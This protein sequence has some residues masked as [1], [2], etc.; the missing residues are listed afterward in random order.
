MVTTEHKES[1]DITVV[2]GGMVGL[3]Q[4]L[5]LAHQLPNTRIAVIENFALN[6]D[7][8]LQPSFDGR[9]TALSASSV[10]LLE[11]LAVWPSL[12]HYAQAIRHVHV[13]DRGHVGKAE[14]SD[15]EN[16]DMPL[17]Y[18]VDNTAFGQQLLN[19]CAKNV[20]I[21]TFAPA[22][23]TSVVPVATGMRV[24]VVTADTQCVISSSLVVIAD[25]VDSALRHK[26]GVG[27]RVHDYQQVAVIA[28]V[29]FSE[30]HCGSAFER[31]T[32]EGPLAVLP[33]L[34]AENK[35]Q[36][37]NRTAVV[38]TR[39]KA[40]LD[41]TLAWSDGEF[42]AQLQRRFGYR[43]GACLR[44]GER[45]FYELKMVFAC[46][47]VRRG[48]VFMG[49]AA[50]FLHPV[51]GQGFNLAVRDCAQLSA[52][53]AEA[54]ERGEALGSLPVLQR[55]LEAQQTDQAITSQLS[56]NFI[57]VFA[58]SHPA[59]QLGRNMGL[60][61]MAL[62]GGLKQQLFGQMMGKALPRAALKRP[63]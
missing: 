18:V 47:Q 44:V 52:V 42:L 45:N 30:P 5:L 39:P 55:Y 51:A 35:R 54:N 23:V 28:N 26:L 62:F 25:G 15:A 34:N 40:A 43:L 63:Q 12:Q 37:S 13:S 46:E 33:M 14:Y 1:F 17:G 48:I 4:A 56:H 59:V 24:D 11:L 53:L 60:L 6:V 7:T 41:E 9:A 27:T 58:S 19:A 50:H 20:S 49:N 61:S 31:F 36:T 29:A 10:E 22:Q 3:A 38:W 16:G 32:D 21:T 57:R 2:G 8:P